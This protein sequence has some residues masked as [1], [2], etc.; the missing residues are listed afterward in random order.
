MGPDEPEPLLR[1]PI[2][3][4]ASSPVTLTLDWEPFQAASDEL[5]GLLLLIG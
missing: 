5:T 1:T 3:Y 4:G 2:I